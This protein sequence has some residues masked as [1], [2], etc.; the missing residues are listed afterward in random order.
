M[1]SS[2]ALLPSNRTRDK[3]HAKLPRTIS[4]VPIWVLISD[5]GH[6]NFS[7]GLTR[8]CHPCIG[9]RSHA[10]LLSSQDQQIVSEVQISCWFTTSSEVRRYIISRLDGSFRLFSLYPPS[11]RPLHI[12][13]NLVM[14][15]RDCK[16]AACGSS[17]AGLET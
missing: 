1:L 3:K 5:D 12:S 7:S 4:S 10:N 2:G 6:L 16:P 14:D 9:F 15:R 13:G 17:K 11:G 8:A